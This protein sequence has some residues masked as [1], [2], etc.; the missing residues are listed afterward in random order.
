MQAAVLTAVGEP[1]AL[2]ELPTPTPGPGEAL[3]ATRTCGICRTDLHIQD[4]L[5]YVPALPHVPGHEPAGVV[6]AVGEG[7]T[8]V[9]AGDRVVPHLF[10]RQRDCYY[11]RQGLDAQALHLD[12]I[13]GVTRPGGFAQY[14]L[15]PAENLLPLPETV[16]FAAGGLVSCAVLTA[17]HA[18]RKAG[19]RPGQSAV[20]LGAGGIGLLLVQLLRWA[21]V[22]CLVVSRSKE[23]LALAR[24][25]GAD[26]VLRGDAADAA[27][28]ARQFAGAERDGVDAVFETVGLAATMKLAAACAA[29]C[30]KI[31]VIG[32]EAEFPA[33]D[34][35][36]IAQ[37]ELQVLGSRNGSRQEAR[38]A[39]DLLAH[40][41]IKPLIAAHYP[42]HQ[43]N[44]ALDAVRRGQV[45][46]R[47][48]IEVPPA[49]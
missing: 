25:S 23:S 35:I 19:L 41:V 20:V 24:A 26:A 39:L 18:L 10:L 8:A 37:R 47:A 32:E 14:F 13:L 6:V 7:V 3:V 11:T 2:V 30:G 5:A 12:G 49:D 22:R 31:I 21:D 44:A 38:E 43:I 45:H 42:L 4:G 1:L 16:S 27:Q 36:Q 48:V 33:I 29:R 17:V 46:G 40:G 9:R 15:A 34:T 28:A